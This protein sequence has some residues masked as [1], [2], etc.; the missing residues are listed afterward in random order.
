MATRAGTPA[1][2]GRPLST[3]TRRASALNAAV[4]RGPQAIL[5]PIDAAA[6]LVLGR[7]DD[8]GGRRRRRRAHVGDE[9]GNRDVGFVAD[10]RDDRHR[11]ARDGARHDLLVEGPQILDRSAAAPDDDDVDAR[12]AGD[13]AQAAGDFERRALALDAGRTDDEVQRCDSA[14]SAP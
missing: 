12:H 10:G 7:D 4:R 14:G 8:L 5:Q 9:V 2:A 11:R 6:E 3:W 1:S 13:C